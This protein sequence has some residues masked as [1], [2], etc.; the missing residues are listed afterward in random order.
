MKFWYRVLSLVVLVGWLTA[1]SLTPSHQ[2][3]AAPA[4]ESSAETSTEIT[5]AA[6]SETAESET[7]E[8][9]AT[10]AT[11]AREWSSTEHSETSTRTASNLESESPPASLVENLKTILA[12]ELGIASTDVLVQETAPIEWSDSCLD[13]PRPDELCA[14]VITPGYRIILS[15]LTQTFEFHTDQLGQ[16]IRRVHPAGQQQE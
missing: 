7:A 4:T 2:P 10:G 16:N 9:K 3:S 8:S 1:C 14:Q 11:D 13:L 5:G 12:T 15:N 6:E